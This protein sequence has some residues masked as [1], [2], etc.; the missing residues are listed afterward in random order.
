MKTL[1]PPELSLRPAK[2]EEEKVSEIGEGEGEKE[3]LVKGGREV[4]IEIRMV[5][6]REGGRATA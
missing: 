2:K 6:V 3:A 1:T 5:E 4:G